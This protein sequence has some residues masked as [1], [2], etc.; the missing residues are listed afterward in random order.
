[1]SVAL[2]L[3]WVVLLCPFGSIRA[4]EAEFSGEV[5][6]V[7]G[8]SLAPGKAELIISIGIPEGYELVRE[9]PILAK[10]TSQKK[11]IL[12]LG[13]EAEK[14]CKNPKFPLRLPLTA[15]PGETQLQVDLVLFYCK[16]K[17]GGLC[18]TKKA[19]LNL[20]VK[21]DKAAKNKQLKASYTLPAI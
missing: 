13:Q 1:M 16:K 18:I 8:Q 4:Q 2:G 11:E 14:T 15:K 21:V 3:V 7:P 6:T 17:G 20:P 9:A 12:V 10:V 5:V 19:R